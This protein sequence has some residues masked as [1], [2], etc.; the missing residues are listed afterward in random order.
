M[1]CKGTFI[2]LEKGEGRKKIFAKIIRNFA[3]A[4]IETMEDIRHISKQKLTKF[5]EETGE[6][7]FRVAQIEEWLWKKG[8]RGFDEM[9]TL[10][11]ALRQKLAENFV[12]LR[13]EIAERVLSSDGTSKYIFALHDGR[14][15][16]GVLI[17]ADSRVTACISSQVGCPLGCKFCATGTMGF[18]RNLHASE[19]FDQFILMNRQ[20]EELYGRHITN[21]VYMGMGEPLLNYENVMLSIERITSPSGQG[22]SPSRITLSTVGIAHGIRRLADDGFKPEV[23]LSLHCA[24][25]VKRAERMPVTEHQT[26]EMLQDALS[27]L[28]QKTGKRITIEYLMLNHWNDSVSDAKK[29]FHFCRA[30]PVKINLIEYNDTQAGYEK[31]PEAHVKSFIDFLESK[32]MVV[33]MRHSRGKDIAAACGQLVKET[34]L[35]L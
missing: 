12:F 29:L 8:A 21:I 3:A 6:K 26:F 19:I 23:A 16:E 22:L 27:Y 34:S 15:V 25:E 14:K 33:N 7:K 10:S 32:N 4:K 28:H 30:F 17:P 5:I 1:R 18:A 2:F 13:T 20:A 31:S 35:D 9:T 11:L 24:D